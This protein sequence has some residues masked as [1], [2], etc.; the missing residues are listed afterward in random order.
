MAEGTRRWTA[1]VLW[2]EAAGAILARNAHWRTQVIDKN[3]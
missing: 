2:W 3:R 1:A